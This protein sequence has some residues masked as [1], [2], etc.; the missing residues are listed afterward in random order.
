[1][2]DQPSTP[3]QPATC[4][5][6]CG[7]PVRPGRRFVRGHNVRPGSP[8]ANPWRGRPVGR[9]Y[10]DK[11]KGSANKGARYSRPGTDEPGD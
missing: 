11:V 2:P 10:W 8:S 1:M 4:A 6:G 3:T 9:P 5:C 7:E